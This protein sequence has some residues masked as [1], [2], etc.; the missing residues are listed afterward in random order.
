M[1]KSVAHTV[2]K[3]SFKILLPMVDELRTV[4]QFATNS[5]FHWPWRQARFEELVVK[6]RKMDSTRD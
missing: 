5:S 2:E 1:A 4:V 3:Y 6:G